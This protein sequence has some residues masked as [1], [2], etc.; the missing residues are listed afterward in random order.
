ML[1]TFASDSTPAKTLARHRPA[2]LIPTDGSVL[3]ARSAWRTRITVRP[4]S[5]ATTK[6]HGNKPA[7]TTRQTARD[8][9]SFIFI[10]L[11]EFLAQRAGSPH[12]GEAPAPLR[13]IGELDRVLIWNLLDRLPGRLLLTIFSVQNVFRELGTLILH[14]L[15]VLFHVPVERHAD[16]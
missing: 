1:L 10:T 14:Y 16:L 6:A 9:F 7:T 2:S 3:P 13:Q 15:C 8:R 12:A 4:G 11:L 5:A